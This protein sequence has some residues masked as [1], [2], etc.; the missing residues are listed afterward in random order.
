MINEV[1]FA[2]IVHFTTFVI[3]ALY[4]YVKSLKKTIKRK[5]RKQTIRQLKQ[6]KRKHDHV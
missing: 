3:I 4:F 6:H 5:S 2:L 1:V